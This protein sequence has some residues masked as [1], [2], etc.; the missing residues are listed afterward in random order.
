M[1]TPLYRPFFLV[2]LLIVVMSVLILFPAAARSGSCTLSWEISDSQGLDHF[3]VYIGTSSG[4]YDSHISVG[5]AESYTF[6][7]LQAGQ[8]YFLAVKA[9]DASGKEIVFSDETT[10][11]VK[12]A[13]LGNSTL[14]GMEKLKESRE[15][16]EK[17]I[18]Q[19]LQ[20]ETLSTEEAIRLQYE[21]MQL[22]LQTDV[23]TKT[24]DK[25]SQGVQTLFK[26]Q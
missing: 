3:N 17:K 11:T 19:L 2:L 20:S 6:T 16:R 13:A 23:T 4:K 14:Q 8:T 1:A 22:N 9:V 15:A 7:G 26:N 25:S 10:C 24:T 21:L 12:I 18:G 5:I